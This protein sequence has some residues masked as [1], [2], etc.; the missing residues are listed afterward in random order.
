[1]TC[2]NRWLA[3]FIV[4]MR[5]GMWNH[6]ERETQRERGEERRTE[7]R[8]E[9]SFHLASL[10]AAMIV[11]TTKDG[12][13]TTATERLRG[14]VGDITFSHTGV[15]FQRTKTTRLVRH[16]NLRAGNSN[17][18][19]A[20][21]SKKGLIWSLGDSPSRVKLHWQQHWNR[22]HIKPSVAPQS[23]L[24]CLSIQQTC[25]TQLFFRGKHAVYFSFLQKAGDNNKISRW[26]KRIEVTS[27]YL[28]MFDSWIT[29]TGTIIRVTNK[30]KTLC[31]FNLFSLSLQS[32]PCCLSN[33]L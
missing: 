33:L 24:S 27:F 3:L 22:M 26:A 1:M 18:I 25:N 7:V 19:T 16:P 14:R 29:V 23:C 10:M 6:R 4:Q 30:Y 32:V 12:W 17:K 2:K 11:S 28:T 13:Q 9:T 31:M 21:N 15:V 8:I 5:G 20:W